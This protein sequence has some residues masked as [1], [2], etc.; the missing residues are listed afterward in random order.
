MTLLSSSV[1]PNSPLSPSQ[2]IKQ[3]PHGTP[4]LYQICDNEGF[5]VNGGFSGDVNE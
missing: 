3:L 1:D 2:T 5:C 4:D